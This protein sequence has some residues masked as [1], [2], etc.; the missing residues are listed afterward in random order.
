MDELIPAIV[1][2]I[3]EEIDLY[4]ELMAH[5]RRKTAL[6]VRGTLGAILESNKVDETYNLKLRVLE[7]ELG[8]LIIQ[9]CQL[10]RI[11]REQ[12]TL[13]RLA[14]NADPAAAEE[15]RS[16]ATLFRNLV[17]QL[18][19]V[20]QRNMRLIEGSLRYSRGLV[21][22]IANAAGSYQ[23]TGLLRPYPAH[24]STLSSRA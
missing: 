13:L 24:P 16:L 11:P 12:F 20:N 14:E 10:L 15:I 21:D 23:S 22:F 5:A 1:Q 3:R 17:E 7:D 6:L 19:R 9:A 2:V 4:R 18:K 8:R